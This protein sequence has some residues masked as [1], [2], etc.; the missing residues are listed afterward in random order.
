MIPSTPVHLLEDVIYDVDLVLIMSVNPGFGGQFFINHTI[1][2]IRKLRGLIDK[3]GRDV[4]IE[5]DGGIS[6][7]NI[8][9]I[10]MAGCNIVVA[11]SYIFTSKDYKK[12]IYSLRN[13]I[14][15][16]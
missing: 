3:A 2:K 9:D 4:Y 13:C 6:D 8:N 7:K 5:V 1:N 11:G 14:T 10:V 12:A 16:L 15:N